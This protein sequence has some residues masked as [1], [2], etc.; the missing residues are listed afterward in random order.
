MLRL[1]DARSDGVV[2]RRVRRGDLLGGAGEPAD[3][4]EVIAAF[5]ARRLLAF[6]RDAETREPTVEIAHDALLDAWSR[7]SSWVEDARE[8]LMDR[9]HVATAARD[10]EAAGRDPSFLLRGVRLARAEALAALGS[11]TERELVSESAERNVTAPR[12]RRPPAGSRRG[13]CRGGRYVAS[14]AS[15]PSSPQA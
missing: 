12:H 11:D 15:S 10:W 1:V 7:L 4:E 8:A 3:V 14:G 9:E 13:L 5:G 2:R 6:D